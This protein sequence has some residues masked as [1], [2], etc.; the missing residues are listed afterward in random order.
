VS[1]TAKAQAAV[2]GWERCQRL[3]GNADF[4]WFLK[5]AVTG[6][7]EDSE[8]K[9]KST[10]AGMTKD[11]RET[12]AHVREALEN[13]EQFVARQRDIYSRSIPKPEK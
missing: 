5:E 13:A 6:P 4:Q 2:A 10:S 3:L 12:A 11:D 8:K 7:R 1:A 9:L